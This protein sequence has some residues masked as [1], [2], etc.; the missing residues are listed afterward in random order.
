MK[1]L[2]NEK[3]DSMLIRIFSG[4]IFYLLIT[5]FLISVPSAF[6][7]ET[8]ISGKGEKITINPEFKFKRFSNGTVEIYRVN[9]KDQKK[10]KFTDFNADLLLSAYR[11][12]N[13]DQIIYVLSKKYDLSR[14]DCRRQMKHSLNI[15][16]DWGI[17]LKNGELVSH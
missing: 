9:D 12:M 7:T 5:L 13:S 16:E 6:P 4:R 14:V 17:V 1:T 3:K 11:H 15:L 10:Y 8:L 2:S